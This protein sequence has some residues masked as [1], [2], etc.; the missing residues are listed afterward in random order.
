MTHSHLGARTVALAASV[1]TTVVALACA[2]GPVT[3]WAGGWGQFY[4]YQMHGVIGTVKEDPAPSDPSICDAT[5]ADPAM[6]QCNITL[7]DYGSAAQKKLLAAAGDGSTGDNGVFVWV[8]RGLNCGANATMRFF[9]KKTTQAYFDSHKDY[10]GSWD[11]TA[12]LTI[13]DNGGN[14]HLGNGWNR[15]T[16]DMMVDDNAPAYYQIRNLDNFKGCNIIFHQ[17]ASDIR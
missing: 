12:T 7:V 10:S 11:K 13:N 6:T 5:K 15:Y 9:Y 4:G 8:K 3:A 2:F 1:V 17:F 16:I 14:V